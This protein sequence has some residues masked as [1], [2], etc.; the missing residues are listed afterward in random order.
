LTHVHQRFSINSPTERFP[1]FQKTTYQIKQK[2][3]QIHDSQRD[4]SRSCGEYKKPKEFGGGEKRGGDARSTLERMRFSRRNAWQ[5]S[6]R[7]HVGR[8][9]RET[10][11]GDLASCVE[12][13]GQAPSYRGNGGSTRMGGGRHRGAAGAGTRCA[14]HGRQVWNGTHIPWSRISP[15]MEWGGSHCRVGRRTKLRSAG[16]VGWDAGAAVRMAGCLWQRVRLR[17]REREEAIGRFQMEAGLE[18]RRS[19]WRRGHGCASLHY[20]L[21]D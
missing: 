16:G 20:C 12:G 5:E 11:A 19:R 10:E 15:S 4:V 9:G 2:P 7:G 1:D 8:H 3:A 6:P 18:I 17:E 14:S 21:K 13:A